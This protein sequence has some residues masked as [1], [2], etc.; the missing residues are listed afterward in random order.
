MPKMKTH[1]G[2]AARF[3]VTGSGKLLRMKGMSSHFRRRRKKSTKRQFDDTVSVHPSDMGRL[4]KLLSN[5]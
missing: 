2:A 3:K 4:R 5:W 1:K